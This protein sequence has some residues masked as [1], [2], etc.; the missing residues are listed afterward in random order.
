MTPTQR[1]LYTSSIA[2]TYIT[3]NANRICL[4]KHNIICL[5]TT[6]QT[7]MKYLIKTCMISETIFT[8]KQKFHN[9][10]IFTTMDSVCIKTIFNC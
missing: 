10:D 2:V 8:T 7:E 6:R 9:A 3:L 5:L 4:Y 1:P